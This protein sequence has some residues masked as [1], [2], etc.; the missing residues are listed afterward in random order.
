MKIRVDYITENKK[1]EFD[2]VLVYQ[3][4]I[5]DLLKQYDD[6]K[7]NF[8][9]YQAKSY[10]LIEETM[11]ELKSYMKK[12]SKTDYE[13]YRKHLELFWIN[14]DPLVYKL[15]PPDVPGIYANSEKLKLL[16]EHLAREF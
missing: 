6:K 2:P 16:G 7:I 4:K 13:W 9:Q 12:I 15:K 5:S 10:R 14:E 11:G 8:L 1:A 3:K